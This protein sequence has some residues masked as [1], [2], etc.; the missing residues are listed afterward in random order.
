MSKQTDFIQT[1]AAHAT[2]AQVKS[3][4]PASVTIAQCILESGWG[5][6]GLSKTANNFF[7]IKAGRSWQG[8]VYSGSTWEVYS[9]KRVNFKGTGLV[10][11]SKDAALRADCPQ[12]TLF[13]YYTTFTEGLV[14]K[15]RVFYNGL[16]DNA[17]SYRGN[18]NEFLIRMAS[19]YA[20]DTEYAAKLQSIIRKYNLEQYDVHPK[21]WALDADVVKGH[22][23]TAWANFYLKDAPAAPAAARPAPKSGDCRV[24]F[25]K[26][27]GKPL[28][29]SGEL[30]VDASGQ[31]V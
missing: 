9:G 5:D 30:W 7:G 2:A 4:I 31:P 14:D 17:L 22:W 29:W 25:D 27:L 16:Y 19:V 1:V 10:Y 6:S 8:M 11:A 23:Y 12:E 13:R 18:S 21:N 20:T 24:L 15:A 26:L 3:G 28:F